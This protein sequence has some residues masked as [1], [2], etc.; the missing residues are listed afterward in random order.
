PPPRRGGRERALAAD[1]GPLLQGSLRHARARRRARWRT[2]RA[3]LVGLVLG[4]AAVVGTLALL[5]SHL[6]VYFISP[7][8]RPGGAVGAGEKPARPPLAAVGG[9]GPADPIKIVGG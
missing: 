4:I 8:P 1:E 3:F 6:R 5:V 9:G 7:P 2:F